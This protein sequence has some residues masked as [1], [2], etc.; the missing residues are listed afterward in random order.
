MS[1]DTASVARFDVRRGLDIGR[2]H[3]E[4]GIDLLLKGLGSFPKGIIQC[5]KIDNAPF[6]QIFTR[7]QNFCQLFALTILVDDYFCDD[8]DDIFQKLIAS[9]SRVEFSSLRP[10]NSCT[11]QTLF[12]QSSLE[13]LVINTYGDSPHLPDKNTNLKKL[14]IS[15]YLIEPLAALLPNITSLTY[16][17]INNDYSMTDSD[18]LVLIDLVQSHTTLEELKLGFHELGDVTEFSWDILTKLP[19][20]IETA[21]NCQKRLEIDEEYYKYLPDNDNDYVNIDEEYY[22]YLPDDNDYVNIDEDN[23]GED[24]EENEDDGESD[25][26]S[27]DND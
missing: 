4:A 7:L 27:E 22:K 16:L 12:G 8:D 11:L 15:G 13:E 2:Y 19:Q 1:Q 5:L 21:V 24:E 9:S 10:M 14:T 26:N 20:F 25:S 23:D 18:L 3:W 6:S 17:R